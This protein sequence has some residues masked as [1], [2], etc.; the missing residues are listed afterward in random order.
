[1]RYLIE[2]SSW[3]NFWCFR[4]HSRN[5]EVEEEEESLQ[6]SILSFGFVFQ[7]LFTKFL[8]FLALNLLFLLSIWDVW[9]TNLCGDRLAIISSSKFTHKIDSWLVNY[10][11]RYERSLRFGCEFKFQT[12]LII[13]LSELNKFNLHSE[14]IASYK[15]RSCDCWY[16]DLKL[17][18]FWQRDS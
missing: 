17:N 1:M 13:C 6:L 9:S 4:F 3:M 14:S 15:I 12:Y 7:F 10:C 2:Q 8:C 11:G 18:L 16:G 5:E